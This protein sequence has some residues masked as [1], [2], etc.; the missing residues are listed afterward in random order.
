[1]IIESDLPTLDIESDLLD[2]GPDPGVDFFG[3]DVGVE[4]A[5]LDRGVDVD[6]DLDDVAEGR[7]G[8]GVRISTST[9]M[10]DFFLGVRTEP[11]C[12][13]C[14]CDPEPEAAND[15]T[16]GEPTPTPTPKPETGVTLALR[17]LADLLKGVPFKLSTGAGMGWCRVLIG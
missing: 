11:C 1:V 16:A 7:V 6:F 14:T 13:E 15:P 5:N 4:E 3:V 17:L 2:L 12:D 9:S 10:P 8:V